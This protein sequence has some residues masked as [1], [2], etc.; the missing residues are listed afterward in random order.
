M[1]TIFEDNPIDAIKY[2]KLTTITI[3]IIYLFF[4][5]K[6][7]LSTYANIFIII[8]ISFIN[9][10]LQFFLEKTIITKHQLRDKRLLEKLC[11]ENGISQ[12]ATK[13][14][15]MKYVQ[16]KT[17][18]EIALIEKVELETIKQSLRRTR[19]KINL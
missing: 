9:A 1:D 8:L 4:S 14:M 3:E 18:Q 2:C 10:L 15:I 16:G 6:F 13:R 7:D 5:L 12:E 17:A 11:M 19:R